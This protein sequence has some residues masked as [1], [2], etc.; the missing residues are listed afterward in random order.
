MDYERPMSDVEAAILR[1]HSIQI[2]SRISSGFVARCGVY[3]DT[4]GYRT[5]AQNLGTNLGNGTSA[6]L[7]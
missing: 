4:L 2:V 3:K 1:R 5:E 6:R 7:L